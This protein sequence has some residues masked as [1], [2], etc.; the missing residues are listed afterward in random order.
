MA[1][2]RDDGYGGQSMVAP[3]RRVILC[4]PEAAGWFDPRR[5][6]QWRD[7]GYHHEPDF[8]AARDQHDALRD[9]LQAAGAEVLIMPASSELSMDAVYVHDASFVTDHGVIPLRMG[10]PARR[11]EPSFH[12]AFFGSQGIPILG[13]IQAPGTAE[14]GDLVWLDERTLL[15]GRSYRTNQG[16]IDQLA[17]LLGPKGIEVIP[18]PLPHGEGPEVCLHLMS[19]MSVLDARTL[20]VDSVWLA[21]ETMELLRRR[22]F[23]LIEIDVSERDALACNVLALGE[24][25][26]L[27]F[28][29]IPRTIERMRRE[30]FQVATFPGREV[31]RNGGGGPTCLTRPL[32]RR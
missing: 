4:A 8:R 26:L 32:L 30:G 15:A 11:A 20:L 18:A 21:V 13:E 9:A 19:V 7:L 16:G 6:G 27:A 3:L 25:S 5:R 2:T 14:S 24:G 29:E 22:D 1:M 23:K 31:G 10:K 12:A 17:A 28:E